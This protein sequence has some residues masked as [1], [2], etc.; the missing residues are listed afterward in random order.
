MMG[1]SQ[2]RIP[3]REEGA[4]LHHMWRHLRV[5]GTEADPRS[6]LS[7]NGRRTESLEPHM[8]HH[9]QSGTE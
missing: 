3:C 8:Q 5:G 4:E 7:Y 1:E 2:L 9:C 6:P